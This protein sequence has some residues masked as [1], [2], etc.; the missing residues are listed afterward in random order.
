MLIK[1]IHDA[2]VK[3]VNNEWRETGLTLT[4]VRV[5]IELG[6]GGGN[7]KPLKELERCFGVAQPTIV[8]IIQRLEAKGLVRGFTHLDDN[9]VK[10]VELTPDGEKFRSANIHEIESVER[11]LLSRLTEAE[12]R[13]FLRMLRSVYESIK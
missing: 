13:D 3:R 8:G 7:A 5:L 11:L 12:Q 2:I 9:R 10:L 4:Q 6:D 1:Q